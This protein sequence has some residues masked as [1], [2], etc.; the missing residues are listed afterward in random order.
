MQF[1]V[2]AYDGTDPAVFERRMAVRQAH[3]DTIA[4]YKAKGHMKMGAALLDDAG[5]MIGSVIIVDFPS[6][7][8]VDEWLAIDPYVTNKVW[9]EIK[10]TPCQIAPSFVEKK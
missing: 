2:L 10:I 9:Q 5:K 1:L 3:I 7:K 4:S 8:E 6:R